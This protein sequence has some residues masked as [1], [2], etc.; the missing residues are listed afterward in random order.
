[1]SAYKS[2]PSSTKPTKTKT[3]YP[4][5]KD[6]AKRHLRIDLDF[7]DDD[8]YILSLI[9]ASTQY[10]EQYIGKDIAYTSSVQEIYDFIGDE[11]FLNEGNFIE[12]SSIVDENST[13]YTTSEE[14]EL[15][16]SIYV[17][18]SSTVDADPLTITYITGFAEGTTPEIIKQAILIDVANLYDRDRTSDNSKRAG[19]GRDVVHRLLDAYKIIII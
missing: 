1:M 2:I 7:K 14:R 18:L 8:A 16:N 5:T 17:K 19:G 4:L 15:Y 3:I 9:K 6:E 10:A 11:L 12:I 13:S